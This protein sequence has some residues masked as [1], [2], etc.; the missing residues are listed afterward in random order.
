[1]QR[2]T[3]QKSITVTVAGTGDNSEVPLSPGDQVSDVLPVVVENE[4]EYVLRR[5]DGE[6]LSQ[7]ADLHESLDAGEITYAITEPVV[8]RSRIERSPGTQ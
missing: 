4:D 8:G 5:A 1:M 3:D 7:E 6:Q 2:M